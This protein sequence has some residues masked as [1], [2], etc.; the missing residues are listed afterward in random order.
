M[1]NIIITGAN[2]GIGYYFAEQL[3]KEGN[4]VAIFD[5]ETDNIELKRRGEFCIHG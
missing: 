4:S 2:Q 5:L 1:S 3:L